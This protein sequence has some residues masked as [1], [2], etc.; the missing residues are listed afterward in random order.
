MWQSGVAAG[1]VE[2]CGTELL[3]KSERRERI[4]TVVDPKRP[5]ETSQ[6]VRTGLGR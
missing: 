6:V 5:I 2:S 1:S 4:D 3:A